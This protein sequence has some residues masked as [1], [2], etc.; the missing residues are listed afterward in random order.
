MCVSW[1]TQPNLENDSDIVVLD[2]HNY[3]APIWQ[4]SSGLTGSGQERLKNNDKNTL[5]L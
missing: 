2:F 1:V 3:F 5:L 4:A